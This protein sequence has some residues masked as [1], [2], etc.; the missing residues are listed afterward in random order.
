MQVS[1]ADKFVLEQIDSLYHQCLSLA[2]PIADYSIIKNPQFDTKSYKIKLDDQVFETGKTVT[3]MLHKSSQIFIFACTIGPKVEQFSK[4]QMQK[5]NPLEACI[6]DLI[7]S[8]MVESLADFLQNEIQNK[9]AV[10]GM[11]VTNRF[12]PGYCNWD[13]KAQHCLFKL[14][15]GNHCNI[16]LTDSSLMV[17]IKSVSG[18]FGVGPGLKKDGYKCRL[19]NN[20][21]CLQ[22]T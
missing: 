3:L 15:K 2:N 17:P 13:I 8:E 5:G 7:G 16:Q 6:I 10:T 22:R 14:L 1:D 20:I 12:S 19:C 9:V 11:G 4:E 21:N 18:I